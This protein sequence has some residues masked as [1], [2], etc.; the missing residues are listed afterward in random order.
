VRFTPVEELE[1]VLAAADD[2]PDARYPAFEVLA[3]GLLTTVQDLGRPG[4]RRRG[5]GGAGAADRASFLLANRALGNEEGAAAIEC[6]VAGPTLRFLR[7][8]RFAITGANLGA[9]L[10]RDDLAPGRCRTGTPCWP[11]RGTFCRSPAARAAARVHRVRRRPST[12][13]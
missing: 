12:Y 8:T 5:I 6:A 10:Q 11:G 4:Q 13:R 1:P 2:Q 9:M 3:S 7:P